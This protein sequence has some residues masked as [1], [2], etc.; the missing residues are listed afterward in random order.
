MSFSCEVCSITF[1][2]K[3]N[4]KRHMRTIHGGDKISHSCSVANCGNVFT[5]KSLRDKHLQKV[6]NI[7]RK[8]FSCTHC[9]DSFLTKTGLKDHISFVHQRLQFKCDICQ[10]GFARLTN[11]TNHTKIHI[12]IQDRKKQWRFPCVQCEEVFE[13]KSHLEEHTDQKHRLIRLYCTELDCQASFSNQNGLNSHLKTVHSD[14]RPF[15]CGKC[16]SSFKT[17]NALTQHNYVHVTDKAFQCSDCDASFASQDRL[18]QHMQMH[19]PVDFVCPEPSC[20]MTFKWRG[21]LITHKKI[22]TEAGQLKQKKKEQHFADF[23]EANQVQ[24]KRE[25]HIDLTCVSDKRSFFRIDFLV[26]ERGRIFM[27]ELDEDAHQHYSVHC[28]TTRPFRIY[29][30]LALEGNT[31]PIV[32]IRL[33]PDVCKVDGKAKRIYKIDRYK[34][35]LELMQ[36]WDSDALLSVVYCYYPTIEGRLT[37]EAEEDFNPHLRDIMTILPI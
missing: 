20:G 18:K 26:Q 12:A 3:S 35:V 13:Y 7:E 9:D 16:S 30:T 14:D 4:L 1:T 33:N 5:T 29:E 27:L 10:K 19:S 6:H 15:K 24:F 37:I 2:L 11:L 22:H 23:L 8:V 21:G 17:K 31:L 32:I 25:H 28:D 34:K 36:Q